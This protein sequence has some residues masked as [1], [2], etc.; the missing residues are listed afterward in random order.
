ME[1]NPSIKDRTF[2]GHEI[3]SFKIP[4][5]TACE[6]NCFM[7]DDCFSFNLKLQNDG[8]Y[9]CELSNSSDKVHKEDLKD[10]EG[11]VYTSF[12]VREN[13]VN[14]YSICLSLSQ[15]HGQ[16]DC[17][18]DRP[19]DRPI[20]HQSDGRINKHYLLWHKKMLLPEK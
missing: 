14:Y 15:T 12:K 5:P 19:T 3:N 9:L 17:Q 16:S 1:I 18:T 11:T 6:V 10:E 4:N 8:T 2:V 7:E 13:K 20:G